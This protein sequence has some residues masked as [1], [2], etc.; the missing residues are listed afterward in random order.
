MVRFKDW[1]PTKKAAPAEN[2]TVDELMALDRHDEAKQELLARLKDHPNDLH[3]RLKLGDAY[4][5]LGQADACQQEY[6]FVAA[7]YSDDGFYDKAR[8]VLTKVSRFFPGQISVEGQMRAL[9]RA[10]NLQYTRDQA[11]AGFLSQSPLEGTRAIEFERLW[12]TISHSDLVDRI[13]SHDFALL[14]EKANVRRVKPGDVVAEPPTGGAKQR[15]VAFIVVSGGLEARA[16]DA[17]GH[18]IVLRV[19]GPG[20][21]VGATVLFGDSTW[22]ARY[23]S[24]GETTLLE[25]DQ[26]GAASLVGEGRK[27][28]ELLTALRDGT[29]DQ[30]VWRAVAHLRK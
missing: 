3:A 30:I 15:P 17:N 4:R 29:N 12:E 8:A 2:L 13:T 25:L 20:E 19:F 7:A 27:P 6:L 14:F 18:E 11:R 21:I 28:R 1:L 26:Q 16:L 22:P 5:H 9:Q 23:C 10:K 24:A